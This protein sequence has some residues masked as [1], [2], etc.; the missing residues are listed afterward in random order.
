M[1]IALHGI[2]EMEYITR[3]IPG[4]CCYGMEGLQYKVANTIMVKES[5]RRIQM[6]S[7]PLGLGD[8]AS[9]WATSL[10]KSWASLQVGCP[11]PRLTIQPPR[12]ITAHGLCTLPHATNW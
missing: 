12:C 10:A 3:G 11:S 1:L 5:T 8:A 2:Y 4:C 7:V 6:K 9:S